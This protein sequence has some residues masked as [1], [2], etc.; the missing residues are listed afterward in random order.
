M[1]YSKQEKIKLSRST[2][3]YI[4]RVVFFLTLFTNK[5]HLTSCVHALSTYEWPPHASITYY[6]T[7]ISPMHTYYMQTYKTKICTVHTF[8]SCALR[9]QSA[10]E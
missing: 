4:C 1:P 3:C 5:R 6:M 2:V 8:I 10:A 9:A 7:I